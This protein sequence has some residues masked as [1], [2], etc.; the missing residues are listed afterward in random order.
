[1]KLE[2]FKEI[3]KRQASIVIFTL[4]CI[5]LVSGVILY[6]T[7]AIFEVKTNQNVINGTVQDPGNIYFAFYYDGAIQKDMPVKDNG[8]VLDEENSFCGVNG[9]QDDNIKVALTENYVIQVHGVTTSR[10]KCNLY[11]KKGI[12]L[13]RHGVPIVTSGDGLY[14]VTHDD[15]DFED[16]GWKNKEYRYAGVSPNNYL[17]FNDETWRII[18]LVN[19]KINDT[20]EQRVK[21]IKEESIGKFSWDSSSSNINNGRGINDW[22]N[23]DLNNLLNNYY[24]NSLS[25][26]KC[27]SDSNETTV[28]CSFANGLKNVQNKIENV[29]WN[30][31]QL[32]NYY[33][34]PDFYQK[35]RETTESYLS[36]CSSTVISNCN[37]NIT[38]EKTFKGNVGL[39]YPSD[40]GYS[41]I[42]G[43]ET[44]RDTCLSK[45]LRAWGSAWQDDLGTYPDCRNNNWLH[46][47]LE[48]ETYTITALFQK[49]SPRVF[50]INHLGYLSNPPTDAQYS[51]QPTLY[52]KNTVKT[53]SGTGSSENHF[54]VAN[55]EP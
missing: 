22:K 48:K 27:Y 8:Y 7:F 33:N 26:Q 45:N 5:F 10:T 31:T 39:L 1:M 38:R 30:T 14:E 25:N 15:I 35:E 20:I 11:F 40:F 6:R 37:D 18:G 46:L 28:D 13:L 34:A 53:I 55:I 2:R 44:N 36:S 21:I 41:T 29:T 54:T 52:L 32:N 47:L 24:W 50:G 12:F 4:F 3:N 51:V 9:S 17:T 43:S 16:A 19:V 49:D 23:A 42:G